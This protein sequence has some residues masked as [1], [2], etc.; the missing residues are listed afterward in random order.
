MAGKNHVERSF[1]LSIDDSGGSPQDISGDIVPGTV[2]GGG[3]NYDGVDM[4][5]VSAG[6]KQSA[7]GYADAPVTFRAHMNDTAS[8]GATTVLNGIVGGAAVT[9]TMQWGQSGA[10]PTTDDPEFEGEYVC[11][12]A[13]IVN[14]GGRFV[15]EVSL[16]PA[17]GASDPAWGTVT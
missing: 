12:G 11:L 8:T 15:H 9:L 14:D 2:N 4:T 13:P 5:G 16:K 1:R 6:V 7:A 17:A 10:A 3:F